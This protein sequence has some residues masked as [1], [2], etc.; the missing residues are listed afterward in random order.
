MSEEPKRRE[1]PFFTLMDV[2]FSDQVNDTSLRL[3]SS[4][5]TLKET[6]DDSVFEDDPIIASAIAAASSAAYMNIEELVRRQKERAEKKFAMSDYKYDVKPMLANSNKFNSSETMKLS[7][8]VDDLSMQQ[9]KIKDEF[10]RQREH[11]QQENLNKLKQ[12]AKQHQQQQ[13]QRQASVQQAGQHPHMLPQPTPPPQPPPPLQNTGLHTV[14]PQQ[15]I[16]QRH[17]HQQQQQQ[18]EQQQHQHQQQQLQHNL[19]HSPAQISPNQQQQPQHQLP[20]PPPPTPP[21]TA[22]QIHLQTAQHQAA[23]QQLLH[24]QQ[25]QL[26]HQLTDPNTIDQYLLS[27]NNFH[28]NMCRGFHTLQKDEKMVDVTI[29]AGGKIFKAHKLVLSVCSPYFQQIFLENPSS[30]PILLMADVEANHMA[31]LLDFMYSGQVNVK[32][33]DLPVFLKVAEAMK[34]KGLHTEKNLDDDS[35]DMSSSHES[36]SS[37]NTTG[38]TECHFDRS[39]HSVNITGQTYDTRK[40]IL[41]LNINGSPHVNSGG[42][43]TLMQQGF[44][45]FRDHIKSKSTLTET[46][47]KNLSRNNNNM[48]ESSSSSNSNYNHLPNSNSM[49][50]HLKGNNYSI[51]QANSKKMLDSTRKQH[52]YLAKRRILMHYNEELNEKRFK[53]MERYG[54]DQESGSNNTNSEVT[55]RSEAILPQPHNNFKIRLMENHLN[56]NTNANTNEQREA[57]TTINDDEEE[58]LNLVQNNSNNN[59]NTGGHDFNK[60]EVKILRELKGAT[61]IVESDHLGQPSEMDNNSNHGGGLRR[62]DDDI[63]NNNNNDNNGREHLDIDNNNNNNNNNN[64]KHKNTALIN[65]IN[66]K[67]QHDRNP[68]EYQIPTQ[69]QIDEQEPQRKQQEQHGCESPSYHHHSIQQQHSHPNL[70][71]HHYQHHHRAN[72]NKMSDDEEMFQPHRFTVKGTAS[73]WSQSQKSTSRYVSKT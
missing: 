34:I 68:T 48:N 55:V 44:P 17:Q 19:I 41:D 57:T 14:L 32:F 16:L 63:N 35:K 1:W 36:E 28:G 60:S 6:I 59:N 18:Q 24:Q 66:R 2:Y 62:C 12:Q 3:F 46:L 50:D 39:T 31:G 21:T 72:I 56:S 15:N 33:E 45:S 8:S 49:N 70:H 61:E 51:L 43:T 27:W 67:V 52:K 40:S 9:Y 11:E 38:T 73:L 7:K 4:T 23:Q 58:A 42:N 47:M 20:P 65:A 71:H 26:Q 10:L 69:T 13:Q 37:V 29:A 30:H 22:Q 53:E 64:K 54:L 25:Q 5:K